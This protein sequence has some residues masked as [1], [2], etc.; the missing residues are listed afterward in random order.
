[1]K[2]LTVSLN[3]PRDLLG[4]LDVPETNLENRLRELRRDRFDYTQWR[5]DRWVAQNQSKGTGVSRKHSD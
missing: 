5:Q 1:M 4:V 2:D 3:L